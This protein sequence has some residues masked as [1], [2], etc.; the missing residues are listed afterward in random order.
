MLFRKFAVL[1]LLAGMAT[2]AYGADPL[3]LIS[4][5]N[6]YMQDVVAAAQGNSVAGSPEFA[7][8][9]GDD[10]HY[11]ASAENC[12]LY[13]HNKAQYPDVQ[14]GVRLAFLGADPVARFPNGTH[15]SSLGPVV[16]G[17]AVYTTYKG[18]MFAFASQTN[19]VAFEMDP[20]KYIPL[21]G[22]YC[23]GAMS[24]DEVTPGDPRNTY[25]VTEAA[26]GGEWGV[27]GSPQGP[28]IWA[29]MTPDD[30]RAALG[31]AIANYNRRTGLVPPHPEVV[32]AK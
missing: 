12:G 29:A 19:F 6:V 31:Q 21:V 3:P 15:D 14:S 13:N 1:A 2:T 4:T 22:G 24:R 11:F 10:V 23:V 28:I 18:A 17:G 25:F 7:L 9:D 8:R 32:A 26:G 16:P 27:F 5:T 20:E 30:R